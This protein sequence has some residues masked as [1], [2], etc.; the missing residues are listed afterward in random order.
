MW[1]L[2]FT[3]DYI[4][5]DYEDKFIQIG[6][7]LV[8]IG[9]LYYTFT[10]THSWNIQ[11]IQ[12]AR[13]LFGTWQRLVI[14]HGGFNESILE[15]IVGVGHLVDDILRHGPQDVHWVY[16]F[17]GEVRNYMETTKNTNSYF[18]NV[19]FTLYQSRTLFTT[20]ISQLDK[21]KDGLYPRSRALEK[22]HSHLHMAQMCFGVNG[23]QSECLHWHAKC[24]IKVNS[25]IRNSYATMKN[26]VHF[27]SEDNACG[28]A[29]GVKGI[30]I[31]A[32]KWKKVQISRDNKIWFRKYWMDMNVL[33]ATKYLG[34]R[35]YGDEYM[36]KF[37]SLV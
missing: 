15:H 25:H 1:C 32:K 11:T 30:L 16:K 13:Y 29:I 3:M 10:R 6:L 18:Y 8:N 27:L 35:D 23:S 24:T 31:G 21:D 14:E 37:C 7:T 34:S 36:Y 5:V 17:E 19:T 9:R 33:D 28:H 2:H 26:H 12:N 20:T 4:K 22:I